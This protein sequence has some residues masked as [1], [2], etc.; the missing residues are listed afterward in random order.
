[1]ADLVGWFGTLCF[2]H[3][4][5]AEST[6]ADGEA[7]STIKTAAFSLLT[8]KSMFSNWLAVADSA[9][10]TMEEAQSAKPTH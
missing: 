9:L 6:T 10:N 3:G 5:S 2:F 4:V 1:M 8:R 7:N